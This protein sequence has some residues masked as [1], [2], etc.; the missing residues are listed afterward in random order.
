MLESPKGIALY[1]LILLCYGFCCFVKHYIW[2]QCSDVIKSLHYSAKGHGWEVFRILVENFTK[3]SCLSLNLSSP[4]NNNAWGPRS[5]EAG[6]KRPHTPGDGCPSSNPNIPYPARD[7]CLITAHIL[8]GTDQNMVGKNPCGQKLH[9]RGSNL[10]NLPFLR[11]EVT[12]KAHELSFIKLVRQL[13]V[14]LRSLWDFWK[15][16]DFWG[17]S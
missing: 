11:V 5:S 12:G 14:Q 16:L 17:V 9:P 15:P 4:S 13:Q 7:M 6:T 8:G 2:T 3:K 10:S 1:L